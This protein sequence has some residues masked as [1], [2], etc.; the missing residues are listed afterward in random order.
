LER[1]VRETD[2]VSRFSSDEFVIVLTGLERADDAGI[3]A[4]K[5]LDELHRVFDLGGQAG[6]FTASIG[7]ALHPGEG[8]TPA[9]LLRHADHAL[10]RA[11]ERGR[12]NFEYDLPEMH[13]KAVRRLQIETA[14]RG[15][16]QRGEFQVR[17]QP[18]VDVKGGAVMG[19]EALLRWQHPEYGLL[20]PSE[21]VPVLEE[22][23]LIVEVG[24]WGL[25][26]VCHQIATWR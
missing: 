14:L 21:F 7:L 26:A 20:P 22:T 24:E 13:Q 25:E 11:K 12:N 5:V 17:Y 2:T 16:L 23:G 1:C 3:F 4:R 9:T 19:F 18:R 10:Y 15:A 6:Y 8:K